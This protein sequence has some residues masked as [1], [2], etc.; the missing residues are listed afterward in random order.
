MIASDFGF[1]ACI[2]AYIVVNHTPG[3]VGYMLCNSVPG[4]LITTIFA[5]LFRSMGIMRF[6]AKAFVTFQDTPSPY[7]PIPV[8]GPILYAT[9]L[10]NMAGLV[11]KGLEGHIANGVPWPAQNGTYNTLHL[12]QVFTH[13]SGRPLLCWILPFLCA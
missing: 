7:Y 3:D 9:L 2:V 11:M 4:H 5:Q 8:F 1:A 12:L 13:P 10:G 6:C